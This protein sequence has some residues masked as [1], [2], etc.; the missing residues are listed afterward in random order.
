MKTETF[1]STRKKEDNGLGVM[2]ISVAGGRS[3]MCERCGNRFDAFGFPKVYI[4][5][6]ND[7]KFGEIAD[8][9]FD[10]CGD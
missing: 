7:V 1:I 8:Q 5:K 4:V 2:G 6:H 3:R 9:V 10:L